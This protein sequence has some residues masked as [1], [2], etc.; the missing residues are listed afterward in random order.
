MKCFWVNYMPPLFWLSS[1]MSGEARNCC[2]GTGC[3]AAF[4]GSEAHPYIP[5]EVTTTFSYCSIKHRHKCWKYSPPRGFLICA[6]LIKLNLLLTQCLGRWLSNQG[7]WHYVL[8]HSVGF[9]DPGLHAPTKSEFSLCPEALPVS[10]MW[11]GN[12][13]LGM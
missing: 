5:I 8:F 2:Q 6:V 7:G 4:L 11:A 1:A 13:K 9:Q 12:L 3:S 10:P